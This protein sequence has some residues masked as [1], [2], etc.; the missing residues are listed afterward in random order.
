MQESEKFLDQEQAIVSEQLAAMDALLDNLS[1]D[2]LCWQPQAD[3]WSIVQC[4]EH[5]NIATELYLRQMEVVIPQA[6]AGGKKARGSFASGFW[7]KRL[8][9]MFAPQSS[10]RIKWKMKTTNSFRPKADPTKQEA[11]ISR[12]KDNLALL[13]RLVDDARGADLEN[14]RIV[15]ALGSMLKLRLGDAIRFVSAHNARHILQAQRVREA[16]ENSPE[17]SMA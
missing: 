14:I 1:P 16:I 12:F 9:K 15:S 10:G 4:L 3:K 5:M 11:V 8:P 13:S 2:Q 17:M 7:G 6:I